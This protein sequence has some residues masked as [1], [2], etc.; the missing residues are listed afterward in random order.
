[1]NS[2]SKLTSEKS[3]SIHL[4]FTTNTLTSDCRYLVYMNNSCGAYNIY[5]K[6]LFNGSTRQV[7]RCSSQLR[8]YVFPEGDNEGVSFVS[9]A[10]D[11]TRN[12]IYWIQDSSVF[13]YSIE[14][15]LTTELFSLVMENMVPG[16]IDI[17]KDGA[18]LCIVGTDEN[19]FLDADTNQHEQ[20]AKVPLR[21]LRNQLGSTLFILDLLKKKIKSEVSIPFWVTHIQ[22]FGHNKEVLFNSEGVKFPEDNETWKRLWVTDGNSAFFSVPGQTKAKRLNHENAVPNKR[23]FVYHGKTLRENIPFLKFNFLKVLSRMGVNVKAELE[24]FFQHFIEIID[25]DGNLL[26]SKYVPQTV[27]HAVSIGGS[28]VVFDSRDGYLYEVDLENASTPPRSLCSHGSSFSSQIAHPHPNYCE[29]RNSIIFCSDKE[30][31]CN[32]Y[33]VKLS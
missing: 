13:S 16:Y 8:S 33:E 9:V 25:M 17:S 19:A 29:E 27:S 20:L 6:N 11:K 18:A 32:L 5:C 26:F 12:I 10:L 21:M 7:T 3:D 28:K 31:S 24:I 23:Q 1:M 22:F 14:Q 30:G 15:D 2:I 4:Y